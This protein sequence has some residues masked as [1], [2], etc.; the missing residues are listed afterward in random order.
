MIGRRKFIGLSLLA[1]L[2]ACTASSLSSESS[3][4][5]T[6]TISAASSLQDALQEIGNLYH[7]QNPNIKLTYN[8]GS[9]GSL[10]HQIEQGAPVDVYISADGQHLDIL[11]DKNLLLNNT[12]QNLLKNEVVLI[13]KQNNHNIDGFS[14]LNSDAVSQIAIG[15]PDSVPAG[16]YAKEV[17][18]SLKLYQSLETKLVFAKNVRQVLAYVETGNVEAGI[19]YSTDAR[20]SEGVKIIATAPIN[21][22]SPIIYP[23]AIV[24][25]SQHPDIAQD[26]SRFLSSNTAKNVFAEYGFKN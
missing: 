11:E 3:S 12:R 13:I 26:F 19:V 17:L 16:K 7:Q 23:V 1:F 6:L 9:S 5:V 4:A 21:S 25:D 15:V 14:Q 18:D 10:R 20:I 8:F 24:R 22:H 2:S